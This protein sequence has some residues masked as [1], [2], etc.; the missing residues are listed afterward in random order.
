[1][2]DEVLATDCR[3]KFTV[4]RFSES[5]AFQWCSPGQIALQIAEL[6]ADCSVELVNST[7]HVKL[8]LKLASSVG[9]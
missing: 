9:P 4:A 1:V 3:K 2:L 7:V 5:I 6:P 8:Q